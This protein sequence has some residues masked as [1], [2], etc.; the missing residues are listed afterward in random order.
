MKQET[1]ITIDSWLEIIFEFA[2]A[3]VVVFSGLYLINGLVESPFY[4]LSAITF[5][6]VFAIRRYIKHILT[7]TYSG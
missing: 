6:L 4:L 5:V 3:V 2:A 7:E 1:I